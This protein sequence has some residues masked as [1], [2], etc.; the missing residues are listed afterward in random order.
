MITWNGKKFLKRKR[1]EE[2]RNNFPEIDLNK[3]P[4]MGVSDIMKMLPHKFIISCVYA[5]FVPDRPNVIEAPQYV[6]DES[7]I[8]LST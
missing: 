4:L 7:L 3:E 1:K 6:S 8:A 2:K 5:I